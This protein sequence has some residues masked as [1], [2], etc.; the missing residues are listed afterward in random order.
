M[1]LQAGMQELILLRGVMKEL[2]CEITVFLAD[3]PVFHKRS[4]RIDI[5]YHWWIRGHVT[6]GSFETAQLHHYRTYQM[7]ADI[8]T[9]SP[10]GS[11]FFKHA[12]CITK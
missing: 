1:A 12:A 4:K 7:A 9:K 5:K 8:F 11:L 2:T 6:P 3:N 10:S